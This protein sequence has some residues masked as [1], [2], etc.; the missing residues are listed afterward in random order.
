MT[1][2]PA[3]VPD[4][5]YARLAEHLRAL[6]G[7]ARLTQR[8]LADAANI[9]RG[10]VQRAESG[11][12]PPTPAILDAYLRACGAGPA[13]QDKARRL[14]AL[15]RTAQRGKL[16]ALQAPAPHLVRDARDF[17]LVLAA[18]Y[19]RAGAPPLRDLDRPGRAR[20][21][22]ATASRI[23]NRHALPSSRQQLI[24]FLTV[25]GIPPAAQRPYLDAYEHVTSQR[26]T[27]PAPPRRQLTQLIRRTHPLPLA[28][29]GP[30]TGAHYDV[31]R[32]AAGIRPAL[33]AFAAH[34]AR[35]DVDRLAA[36]IRPA[37]EA[38][39]AHRAR[40]YDVDRLAAGIRPAL[41]ALA[42]DPGIRNAPT[43]VTAGVQVFADALA[44]MSRSAIK[45]AHRNGTTPP[46]WITATHGIAPTAPTPPPSPAPPTTAPPSTRSRATHHGPAR[47]QRCQKPPPPDHHPHPPPTP[48]DHHDKQQ[49]SPEEG[50]ARRQAR[51]A[52]G[53]RCTDH[54]AGNTSPPPPR[55]RS[56]DRVTAGGA[57][58]AG[59]GAA[60]TK[61]GAAPSRARRGAAGPRRGSGRR[62]DGEVGGGTRE[63]DRLLQGEQTSS[64]REGV[65][66][67]HPWNSS[68]ERPPSRPRRSGSPAMSG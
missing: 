20:V 15:G 21:P 37:V 53:R 32:L 48:P 52:P 34:C 42:A 65:G 4:R 23:V 60:G 35:Y 17:S 39:A 63:T 68:R 67:P 9:S 8:T 7:A 62:A 30:D 64:E 46:S 2:F 12:A 19:E 47:P 36:G 6:R 38:L 51:A 11:T 18:A 16:R 28:H 26:S 41:E 59:E 29:G 49:T 31:D 13:D 50:A 55:G 45:E 14:H 43:V 5:P 22:L 66:G 40:Y 56:P 3:A 24:T 61:A 25:C 27:R 57:G 54:T 58:P 44:V 33:E 1:R 10:A